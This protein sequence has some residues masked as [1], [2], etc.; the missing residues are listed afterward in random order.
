MKQ[1]KFKVNG[2]KY[3]VD[4]LNAEDNIIDLEV[5]GTAYQVELEKEVKASKTPKIVRSPIKKPVAPK[6]G[7]G[8]AGQ[9]INA[10]L[11]G[12]IVE[13]KVKEG[14]TV[15]VGDPLLV[16]E[17]MKM[18]NIINADAAGTVKSIKVSVGDNVLQGDVLVELG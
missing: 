17:A 1:Y 11:P 8:G 9:K 6:V 3:T 2:N 16:M 5:N 13:V 18:E 12:T 15:S 4:I 14:D 7:T 10:P